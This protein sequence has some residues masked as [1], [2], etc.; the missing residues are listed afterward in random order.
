VKLA[1]RL[2]NMRTMHAVAPGKRQRIAR[3][4]L[5]IYAPIAHRLGFNQ[6]YRELQDLAFALLFPWRH[7]VLTKALERARGHRRDIVDRVRQDVEKA[8]AAHKLKIEMSGREKTT[9][10]IYRKMREKHDG[11]ASVNDIFGFRVVVPELRDC[12]WALGILHQLYKP[13]PG[14]FKDYI[15]IPKPPT[16]TRACTPRSSA[17]WAP[18]WSSRFAPRRCTRWPRRASPRTGCTRSTPSVRSRRPGAGATRR[19]WPTPSAW[20]RCGCRA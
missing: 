6:V 19:R 3:E 9:F 14:R 5:D 15:A 16:A 10:S 8:F 17:R 12:Y 7:A 18:R 11:F 13:M 4:T 20:V 1:D 2:H